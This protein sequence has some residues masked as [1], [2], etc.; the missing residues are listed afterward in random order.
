MLQFPVVPEVYNLVEPHPKL[1][2][3]PVASALVKE[4]VTVRITLPEPPDNPVT[5]KNGSHVSRAMSSEP[6]LVPNLEACPERPNLPATAKK[7]I[8]VLP[9]SHVMITE[10]DAVCQF[11]FSETVPASVTDACPERSNPPAMAMEAVSEQSA[12]LVTT[13]EA[14]VKQP[15]PNVMATKVRFKHPGL[16][17][18]VMEAIPEQPAVITTQANTEQP[19]LSAAAP[20]QKPPAPVPVP[21]ER[22]PVATPQSSPVSVLVV[23]EDPSV[24]RSVSVPEAL[25]S[26]SKSVPELF[27]HILTRFPKNAP[28]LPVR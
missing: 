23:Q 15:T 22:P 5:P 28:S 13:I 25:E 17:A 21:P 7:A 4:S 2:N 18:I 12:H 3:S 11:V 14:V 27:F 8:S 1:P 9:T 16:P 19:V 26:A 10:R 20:T 24:S 6:T